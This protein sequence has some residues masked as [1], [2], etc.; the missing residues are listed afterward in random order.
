MGDGT[1]R[2]S[3]FAGRGCRARTPIGLIRAHVI[4]DVDAGRPACGVCRFWPG[5]IRPPS[6]SRMRKKA[7]PSDPAASEWNALAMRARFCDARPWTSP[8]QPLL[9]LAAERMK[10]GARNGWNPVRIVLV[11]G[12]T[13]SMEPE[14]LRGAANSTSGEARACL[15]RV[16]ATR[17]LAVRRIAPA[18]QRML[19]APRSLGVL[20]GFTPA[21]ASFPGRRPGGLRRSTQWRAF[22]LSECRPRSL[23]SRIVRNRVPAK[24]SEPPA[25]L[26]MLGTH[27]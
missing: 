5:A 17:C 14:E 18:L 9:R 23:R 24:A 3:R 16:S 10:T 2:D 21:A 1:R 12:A 22:P 7:S 15:R 19:G 26:H 8:G 25:L 11:V 13:G 6:L 20:A 27:P 4:A